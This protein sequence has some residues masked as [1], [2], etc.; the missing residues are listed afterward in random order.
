MSDTFTI[1]VDIPQLGPIEVELPTGSTAQDAIDLAFLEAEERYGEERLVEALHDEEENELVWEREHTGDEWRLKE[2]R[3]RETGKWW[4]EEEILNYRDSLLEPENVLIHSTTSYTLIKP[5]TPILKISLTLPTTTSMT[6]LV[7]S[8]LVH[9]TTSFLD[10][11]STLEHELGLPK[12][13]D[14]LLGP[15]STRQTT[16]RSRSSSLVDHAESRKGTVDIV[17]W[18]LAVGER[19]LDPKDNVLSLMRGRGVDQIQ[20]SLDD[21]WLFEKR[22]DR[23]EKRENASTE[24]GSES[25]K[26]TLK[27]STFQPQGLDTSTLSKKPQH[28]PR[29]SLSELFST[30]TPRPS[31]SAT[32]NIDGLPNG[33]SR[34]HREGDKVELYRVKSRDGKFVHI[35]RP[36]AIIEGTQALA[37][38]KRSSLDPPMTG[39][40][41]V[42]VEKEINADSW[43]HLLDDLNPHGDKREAMSSLSPSRKAYLLAQHHQGTPA[44]P[45]SPPPV[46]AISPPRPTTFISLSTGTSAG[47]SCLLP[48]LTGSPSGGTGSTPTT[49]NRG[50]EGGWKRFSLAGLGVWHSDNGSQSDNH[51]S[52]PLAAGEEDVTT[53]RAEPSA[54]EKALGEVSEIRPMEKQVTGGVW[55]WWTGSNK[56]DEGTPA[57]YIEALKHSR[58]NPQSLLKHLLS[59]RVTLST[60]K[61]SWI[62]EFIL[63]DGLTAISSLL[64]KVAREPRQKSDIGEQ[65]IAEIGKSLRV[66]MN[67]DVGFNATLCHQTL[68]NNPVLS[69]RTPSY[70][71]RNQMLD[72]LTA[73]VTLSPDTGSR[74]V[75]DALSELKLVTQDKY[76]FSWFVESMKPV[77]DEEENQGVWEWRTG[78]VALCSALCN[79]RE[80]V[81]ERLELRGEL[82]RRGFVKTLQDLE[83]RE[84]PSNFL[85][86]CTHYLDDQEDDLMEFR[87]LFLGEVQNADLA[88]AVGRLLSIVG[89]DQVKGLVGVIEELAEI[90]STPSIRDT[91][92]S[93]LSCFAGH[94]SRLDDLSVDWSV[95]L[96]SFL[97]DLYDILPSRGEGSNGI[98]E[99][100]LIESFVR[101]VHALQSQVKI[102]EDRNQLLEKQVEGQ[103]AEL[104][105]LKELHGDKYDGEGVVHHLVVKEKEIQRLQVEF[106][107]LK[108]HIGPQKDFAVNN[109][110][111]D[112]ERLRFDALM[113]EV[114][115]L[116]KNIHIGYEALLEKQKEVGY[117]ERAI[118]TIQSCF[119]IQT[120]HRD[121]DAGI[122]VKFDADFIVNEAVKNWNQQ[123]EMIENLRKEVEL[124][125]KSKER[126]TELKIAISDKKNINPSP[127]INSPGP[128]PPPPPP[129]PPLPT[130]A[131]PISASIPLLNLLRSKTHA[132][133]P[134]SPPP[135]P[136]PHMPSSTTVAPPPPPPPPPLPATTQSTIS[137]SSI[138]PTPPPPPPPP[139]P[140]ASL[141]SSNNMPPPPP[142]PLPSSKAPMPPPPP[143]AGAGPS[144]GFKLTADAISSQPK[145]KPFFWS[146]MPAYAVKDTIWTSL[147]GSDG[148]DLEF[149]DLNEVFSVDNGAKKLDQ[150][151]G[152]GKEVV[153]FLDIT[154]SN[155][156]GIML[157]RLRLSPSKIRRAIIEVDDDL[158]DIDDLAT[159]SRMLPTAEEAEKI[160]LFSG[161]ISKLSKPDLYFKEISSIPNLKLRLETMVL[162]RKFEMM[163]NEIMPDLMILKNV[164]KELRGSNRLREVLKV[165]L[166]LGNRLNGGTFRGNA[167]GFQ[168]EALL[169]MK[170][171]RT[172][173]GS[174]C[175]TMLHYLAKILLRRNPD[176][177]IWGEDAPALEPAARIVISE[178]ASSIS[179]ISSSLE[180]ARSFHP[181]LSAQDNL[182]EILNS[183]LSESSPKVT[184]LKLT[185]EE[186][187]TD[188]VGLLR[189]FGEKSESENDVE[190]LFGLLSSFSRSLE[191]ASNEMSITMLK[192]QNTGTSVSTII[193][194]ASTSTSVSTSSTIQVF[195]APSPPPKMRQPS[196]ETILKR[197]ER[198]GSTIKRGQVDEAIRTLHSGKTLRKE[199]RHGNMS[200]W[201]TLGVRTGTLGRK[202]SQGS[203]DR[204]RLSKMFLDGGVGGSVKGTIG[205]R[206]IRG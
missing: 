199:R 202:K 152:K 161:D 116:R 9:Q 48:Q 120:R 16:S 201:G 94:L 117:L 156:I 142:P 17:R 8:V 169:K 159:L 140:L 175:P 197:H 18:K 78:V 51:L 45:S 34:D 134:P 105:V 80:E 114:S 196:I 64:E 179:E 141:N 101:E 123:E 49:P 22:K 31:S 39:D 128:P 136:P 12:T 97:V 82:K 190:R 20:M 146:K 11:V 100:A 166:V 85:N 89:G 200:T 107:A 150:G 60:V 143:P 127:A 177:V 52:T 139:L 30:S 67:T 84:P 47:I 57:G 83:I 157:T 111:R 33:S 3:E 178:L 63:L 176:L 167:A 174:G 131:L 125:K 66:L 205:S 99:G 188:L 56:A 40:G 171:T 79:A 50:K 28:A 59:L 38:D 72:L 206:S 76:R 21:D 2:R 165:V 26:S 181:L 137:A 102:V 7:T 4:D 164:V 36:L 41:E 68:L 103:S 70:R 62:N 108:E 54:A 24:I 149:Q 37:E 163:L 158:L 46:Q 5:H 145:L 198:L 109:E 86:Q 194:N 81:E 126:L 153:T 92:G 6:P 43:E 91:V 77:Q 110:M 168:L 74:L 87:E 55:A 58:K 69:L 10:I 15:L 192:E 75:L 44:I 98:T 13:S 155:N 73:M 122:K 183:F 53:P 118:E 106:Q 204:V 93:I 23:D 19:T 160:R 172:A 193:S 27:A 186:I 119:T 185:Y 189:Y 130:P 65:I 90:A 138:A 14:D 25:P 195:P 115:E 32:S 182:H 132:A 1:T 173:K 113:E 61:L 29:N 129:P 104:M 184:Q 154:R 133:A 112:R 162:R 42:E 71:I 35:S 151:K 203:D 144:R 88:V 147:P 96:R 191:I 124:L 180:A 135:P 121:E 95:L 170:D 187:R 148:L